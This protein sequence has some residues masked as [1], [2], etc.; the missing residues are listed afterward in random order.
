MCRRK[1][2]QK[3]P[4]RKKG[5]PSLRLLVIVRGHPILISHPRDLM[6]PSMGFT[7]CWPAMPKRFSHIIRSLTHNSP[8]STSD[9][10]P[11][12]WRTRMR[13]KWE[14]HSWR[15]GSY[16]YVVDLWIDDHFSRITLSVLGNLTLS[17]SWKANSKSKSW[18]CKLS[19]GCMSQ[20]HGILCMRRH[21][22]KPMR[23]SRYGDE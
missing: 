12:K 14:F 10:P 11:S 20:T 8:W 3:D 6:F 13:T 2:A 22:H 1:L 7:L 9:L 21:N 5:L 16:A 15:L 17:T 4:S 18:S 23:S 19:K